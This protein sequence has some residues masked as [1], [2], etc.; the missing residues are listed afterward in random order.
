MPGGR[1]LLGQ[2]LVRALSLC[3]LMS[4]LVIPSAAQARMSHAE[5]SAVKRINGL[6]GERGLSKLRADGRLAR[7]ADAHSRDMLRADFF[8]HPS[9]N[10]TSTFDRV[11]HYRHSNLI[12]ETLAYMPVV[13]DTSA[14]SIVNMWINSPPH[15]AVM[16]TADFRSIGVAKRRGTLF[17][18][19]VT[20][21][22]ADFASA[23]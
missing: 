7:A 17:G 1:T 12:G 10:G 4:M 11:Q 13:G 14:A 16:T 21:W 23:R 9:S 8:A 6:R 18:Q 3:A 15:L 22:T 5:K 19:K 2:K 20:V